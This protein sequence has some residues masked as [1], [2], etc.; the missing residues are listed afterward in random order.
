MVTLA[1]AACIVPRM[2]EGIL[3]GIRCDCMGCCQLCLIAIGVQQHMAQCSTHGP[4]CWLCDL[5]LQDALVL[6]RPAMVMLL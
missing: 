2:R 6:A 4:A 5:L 3:Q 1:V